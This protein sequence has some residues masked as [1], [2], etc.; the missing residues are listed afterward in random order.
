[1]P[2]GPPTEAA[3]VLSA[4]G[5]RAGGDLASSARSAKPS[6]N[7]ASREIRV[8]FVGKIRTRTPRFLSAALIALRSLR[9]LEAAPL[10]VI[11]GIP[12]S[13]CSAAG[14]LRFRLRAGVRAADPLC[15]LILG[16]SGALGA[17]A[18]LVALDFLDRRI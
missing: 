11:F 8:C 15:E 13:W 16:K 2:L 7:L 10:S 18:S 4:S 9:S 3:P 5:W 17:R 12:L 6:R 1:M 14:V